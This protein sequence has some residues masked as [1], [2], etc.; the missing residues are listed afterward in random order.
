MKKQALGERLRDE[1]LAAEQKMALALI[2]AG[3]VLVNDQPAYA[4]QRVG[5]VDQVRLKSPPQKYVAKGGLKLQGALGQFSVSVADQVCL[6]AGASTGGFTDCL[7][8]HAA[9]LVYAVDVGFGQLMGSLRQDPRV[10]NLE[11]TNISHPALLRLDPAPTL[12]TC[13]LSYLSLRDAIP[14]FFQILRRRGEIVALVKPLFETEDQL[15]RRSGILKETAYEPLLLSLINHLNLKED[16]AIQN[17]CE[18]PVRG[19]A[20]T[21]EFFLHIV[22]GVK[23]AKRELDQEIKRSVE[24]AIET[25]N[26]QKATSEER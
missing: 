7:L 25:E 3:Q 24:R 15:A 2:M 23:S 11:R 5:A 1:G 8:Q 26:Y 19:N 21:I 17:I 12:A 18:S 4:G 22:P 6:D 16:I 13:D 9:R 10:V 20:G 14:V